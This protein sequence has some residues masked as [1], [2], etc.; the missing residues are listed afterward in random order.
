MRVDDV[1]FNDIDAIRRKIADAGHFHQANR[2]RSLCSV[3]FDCAKSW[4]MRTDGKNPA[5]DVRRYTEQPRHHFLTPDEM[6]AMLVALAKHADT[7]S[8]NSI[9]LLLLTGARK[10]EV[11]SMRWRDVV[12]L[13]DDAKAAWRRRGADL[14]QG[15]DHAVALTG[16]VRM[17]LAEIADEQTAHGTKPLPEYVFPSAVSKSKHLVEVRKVWRHVRK[18]AKLEHV[19]LHDLRHTFASLGVSHG[20]SLPLVGALLGH[21]KPSTTQRYAEVA[22]DPQREAMGRLG[23]IIMGSTEPAPDTD[24][25][26]AFPST[27][28]TAS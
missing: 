15:R 8:A 10:S 28:K 21:R 25:P 26:V 2:L 11:M 24:A 1:T 13:G 4:Q 5:D 16:P 23:K 19:R 27:R 22:L 6:K 14:K 9:K 12:N 20:F 3:M 17:L 18:A 7:R